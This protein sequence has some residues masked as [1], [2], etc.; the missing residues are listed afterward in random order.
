MRDFWFQDAFDGGVDAGEQAP[1]AVT[2]TRGF[3]GEVVVVADKHV[4][5]GEGVDLITD[6]DGPKLWQGTGRV[7]DDVGVAGVG[8]G[9]PRST[10]PRRSCS[11]D[12]RTSAS[13]ATVRSAW[14]GSPVIDVG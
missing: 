4:E 1:D 10:T 14:H 6:V 13:A 11:T 5:F 12:T 9:S 8:A 7:G 2:H 3:G